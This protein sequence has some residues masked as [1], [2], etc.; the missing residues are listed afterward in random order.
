MVKNLIAVWLAIVCFGL[1]PL[2]AQVELSFGGGVFANRLTD[3]RG[4]SG[5]RPG[6]SHTFASPV[7]QLAVSY[8]INEYWSARAGGRF[9]TYSIPPSI[10]V[11]NGT[12]SSQALGGTVEGAY[13]PLRWLAVGAGIGYRHLRTP[14][15]SEPQD[16]W[17]SLWFPEES[18]REAGLR[19]HF[20]AQAFA[21]AYA[22]HFT[23]RLSPSASVGRVYGNTLNFVN[24]RVDRPRG[25]WLGL[26]VAI[27]YRVPFGKTSHPAPHALDEVLDDGFGATESALGR[28]SVGP[29]VEYTA[30]VLNV[31]GVGDGYD[32]R[33]MRFRTGIQS[34]YAL[35]PD[36]RLRLSVGWDDFRAESRLGEA[37]L[38][39]RPQIRSEYRGLD[40]MAGV[41]RRVWRGLY[42]AAD[43][44]VVKVYEEWTSI[45]DGVGQLGN[46]LGNQ[47]MPIA[48]FLALSDLRAS[49]RF[50]ERFRLGA[51]VQY[52]LSDASSNS[53]DVLLRPLRPREGGWIGVGAHAAVALLK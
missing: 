9:S 24:G 32:Q 48:N 16:P 28:W 18:A 52:T 27:R 47:S 53:P 20:A 37:A 34:A 30:A 50:G 13:H 26:D 49:Y 21:E 23:L 25:S 10:R 6:S 41:E 36:W 51:H 42:V 33:P 35:T 43:V 3:W 7:V 45:S 38:A 15:R 39:R 29:L 11:G 19:S 46:G 40:A 44:G 31:G 22:G 14:V 12:V 1:S 2:A 4:S 8:R 17:D 5:V